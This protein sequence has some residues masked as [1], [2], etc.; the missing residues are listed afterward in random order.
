ME[1]TGS[2]PWGGN[3][4]AFFRVAGKRETQRWQRTDHSNGERLNLLEKQTSQRRKSLMWYLDRWTA[5]Q[6]PLDRN[7]SRYGKRQKIKGSS[8]SYVFVK[9]QKSSVAFVSVKWRTFCFIDIGRSVWIYLSLHQ[10]F[11][12]SVD[13]YSTTRPVLSSESQ[14]AADLQ[15]TWSSKSMEV[16]NKTWGGAGKFVVCWSVWT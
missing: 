13:F 9:L 7:R 1:V 11:C 5:W 2:E 12:K 6:L 16:T 14:W 10:C 15:S 8:K 3:K 4:A